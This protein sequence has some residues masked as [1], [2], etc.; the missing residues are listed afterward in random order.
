MNARHHDL[1]TGLLD[2]RLARTAN[3]AAGSAKAQARFDTLMAALGIYAAAHLH[4]H[5]TRPW[6]QGDWS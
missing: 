2:L 6:P 4:A 5:G 1:M 3:D